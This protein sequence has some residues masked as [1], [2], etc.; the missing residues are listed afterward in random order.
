MVSS[1]K[2]SGN[3]KVCQ[4]YRFLRR[5]CE[6]CGLLLQVHFSHKNKKISVKREIWKKK[7]YD[8]MV[9]SSITI[10]ITLATSVGGICE[11]IVDNGGFCWKLPFF[12]KVSHN[13][14]H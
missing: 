13:E 1:A 6:K 2:R 9:I 5:K 3:P 11:K 12:L 7:C 8:H 10:L 14:S 4:C